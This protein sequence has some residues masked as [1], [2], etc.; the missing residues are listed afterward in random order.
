[1]NKIIFIEK[2]SVI[3]FITIIF[4]KLRINIDKIIVLNN[5][6]IPRYYK[7]FFK[8][9]VIYNKNYKFIRNQH[10]ECVLSLINR[11][12]LFWFYNLISN[13]FP[14]IKQEIK[15]YLLKTILDDY[16]S[17]NFSITFNLI[18]FYKIKD[19]CS[20]NKIDNS[21]VIILFNERPWLKFYDLFNNQKFKIISIRYFDFKNLFNNLIKK[22]KIIRLNLLPRKKINNINKNIFKIYYEGLGEFN[23]NKN[24][25][26]S[27]LFFYLY[28]QLNPRFIVSNYNNKFEKI[29][30]KESNISIL[31]KK[32]FNNLMINLD[33]QLYSKNIFNKIENKYINNTVHDFYINKNY[34][35]NLFYLNKIKVYL[36]WYKYRNTHIPINSALNDLGGILCFWDRSVEIFSCPQLKTVGDVYFK[37][38]NFMSNSEVEN[39]SDIKNYINCGLIR[40]YGNDI[41]KKNSFEI[42]KKFFNSKIEKIIAL[43]D[44]NSIDKYSHDFINGVYHAILTK[45]IKSEN[46]GLVIK[47]KKSNTILKRLY[48]E[49]KILLDL[50]IKQ[51]K[52]YIFLS[53]GLYQSNVPV[54]MAAHLSDVCLHTSLA[55]STAA[56]ECAS[57]N[58]STYII[59]NDG[60]P[61]NR[62][63]ETNNNSIIFKNIDEFMYSFDENFNKNKIK[64][65]LSLWSKIIDKIDNFKDGRAAERIGNYLNDLIYNINIGENKI[66]CIEIANKNYIE[67]WGSNNVI[68]IL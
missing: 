47:P 39:K 40:S 65:N 50:A 52:C 64:L 31:N 17:D 45:I 44:Q 25:Y 41:I 67:Q 29:E 9:I 16:N 49:T 12:D 60:Y 7:L 53:H 2:F 68:K 28:S 63:F 42:R 37:S 11:R 21:N 15:Y 13:E 23:L 35:I 59:D 33:Y 32:N 51:K 24:G 20:V 14:N 38:S 6:K 27:D 8:N 55:A 4:L 5:S 56:I 30:L 48:K 3:N 19:Y 58:K 54:T 18:N 62:F 34:W 57:I 10:G 66:D 43:F 61:N 22:I 46:L 26:N 36:T 1:M